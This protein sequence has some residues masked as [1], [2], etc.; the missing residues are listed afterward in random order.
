MSKKLFSVILAAVLAVSI[1]FCFAA[2]GGSADT[3]EATDTTVT[4][5]Q[6]EELMGPVQNETSEEKE[7][8]DAMQTSATEEVI[9]LDT[10]A[11]TTA[12]E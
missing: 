11:E 5:E 2:C 3:E 9:G 6:S 10:T 12:A 8:E 4:S 1:L 7:S